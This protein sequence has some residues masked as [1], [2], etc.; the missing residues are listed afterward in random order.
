MIE[1]FLITFDFDLTYNKIL[2]IRSSGIKCVLE[3]LILYNNNV[4][5]NIILFISNI[6]FSFVLYLFE[7]N[8]AFIISKTGFN[9]IIK[10]YRFTKIISLNK[11]IPCRKEICFSDVDTCELLP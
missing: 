2:K 8:N 5:K 11:G 10:G 4:K 1:Y 3:E 7:L 6:L 9:M